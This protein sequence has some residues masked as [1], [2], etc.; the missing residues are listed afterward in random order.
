MT[1][2]IWLAAALALSVS[3]CAGLQQF[4]D[5]QTDD[6]AAL[7]SLD[8]AAN[9]AVKA[10]YE[11]TADAG[12][13]KNVRNAFIERRLAVIDANYANFIRQ[14]AEENATA[15]FA[16]AVA[17]IGTGA[18]GALVGETASQILSALS[19][20]LA[21][22]QAAYSKAVLYEKTLSA[23]VAQMSASRAE[24]AARILGR[25]QRD[26]EG[27]PLWMA[28][29]D[30]DAYRFAGSIPGAIVSTAGD[31]KLKEEAAIKRVQLAALPAGAG[32][33][34]MVEARK[35]LKAQVEALD[36]TQ[37]DAL[38]AAVPRLFPHLTD[39]LGDA[40]D[41]GVRRDDPDRETA[42][43]VLDFLINRSAT[44]TGGVDRWRQAIES[45]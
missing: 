26:V 36:Q 31:A 32:S 16:V 5:H 40:Y 30:L 6:A 35:R 25:W 11:A 44:T 7:E 24:I 1:A 14:L 38:M 15:D 23:L 45:L 42:K 28:I 18:A 39:L 41:D 12:Q 4:P 17:G 9:D 3:A 10:I 43:E 2:R 37:V 34:D 29:Q 27:Y 21:G 19:G 33:V 13:K 22:A 8:K 20:G